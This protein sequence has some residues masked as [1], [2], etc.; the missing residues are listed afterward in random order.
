[1]KTPIWIAPH[2]FLS[3]PNITAA[4]IISVLILAV[5]WWW[6]FGPPTGHMGTFR[7][8]IFSLPT[9]PAVPDGQKVQMEV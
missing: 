3:C 8:V 4:K 6:R 5:W 9:V 2:L 7:S 1:M